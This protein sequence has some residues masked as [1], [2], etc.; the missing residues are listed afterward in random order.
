MNKIAP[1]LA[2][3][4]V[5]A[6]GCSGPPD[7]EEAAVEALAAAGSTAGTTEAATEL[8]QSAE[9]L[10]GLLRPIDSPLPDR[11]GLEAVVPEPVTGLLALLDGSDHLVRQNAARSLGL[12]WDVEGVPDRL[13]ELAIDAGRS[14]AERTAALEGM[15]RTPA[16]TRDAHR[17]SI[18][19]LLA[20]ANPAIAAAAIAALADLPDSQR[21]LR[22][23]A[24]GQDT[25][26]SVRRHA[27]RAL[28]EETDAP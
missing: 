3:I 14:P 10:A 8:S 24:D 21:A 28:G 17:A 9:A 4:T 22:A 6:V 18:E 20:N 26:A 7:A 19:A 1:S 2:L 23:V 25:H 15:G 27:L 5:L 11:A 12:F 13:M 16:A